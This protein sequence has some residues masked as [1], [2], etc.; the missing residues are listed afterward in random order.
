MKFLTSIDLSQNEIQNAIMQPLAAP[1][2]NPKIGQI[3]FNSIDLTLYLWTG[4]K[5][6]PVPTKTSQL[7]NDSGS[8]TI[9][10]GSSGYIDGFDAGLVGVKAEETTTLHLTFPDPYPNNTDLS[11]KAVEFIVR[12]NSIRGASDI[13]LTDEFIAGLEKEEYTTVDG[14]RAY[15][16]KLA[17]ED[18]KESARDKA[19]SELW[20]KVMNSCTF[21]SVPEKEVSDYADNMM[22]QYKAYADNYSLTMEEFCEQMMGMDY[23]TFSSQVK[24][25]AEANIKQE[26]VLMSIVNA[27]KLRL[28]D[29]EY[30]AGMEKIKKILDQNGQTPEEL[31]ALITENNKTEEKNELQQNENTREN[32]PQKDVIPEP[33]I[34]K[35]NVPAKEADEPQEDASSDFDLMGAIGNLL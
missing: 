21:T 16:E 6:I 14:L 9:T 15:A 26:I 32:V 8:D 22:S 25:Y 30:D 10:L 17:L 13:D 1:P 7:E 34:P 18:N 12:V 23:D 5:W 20:N 27:E 19:V 3:Y 4:E 24:A 35:T 2:A 28:T 33:V 11:G 29:K 31:L